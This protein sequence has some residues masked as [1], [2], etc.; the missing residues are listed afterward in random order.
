MV[1]KL[2][3]CQK[4]TKGHNFVKNKT[5]KN[6]KS[7]AYLQIMIEHSAKFPVNSIKDVAGVAGTRYESARAI[8]FVKNGRNKNQKPYAHLHMIRRQ[9]IKFQ[10]N[11]MKD[12]NRSCGDK[13]G[14][15]DERTDVHMDRQ[16]SFL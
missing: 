11:P 10:I 14:R 9:S 3:N 6:S 16:G 2:K 8:T 1:Q 15:T 12:I 4:M 7:H 13:I 5:P